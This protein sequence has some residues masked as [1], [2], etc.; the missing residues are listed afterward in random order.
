MAIT[1]VIN[2]C[3]TTKIYCRPDCPAGRRTKPENR[4]TFGSSKEARE[5]GYRA[6]KICKP[7]EP[8]RVRETFFLTRYRGPLGAYVLASSKKGIVCVKTEGQAE[9]YLARW[10]REKIELKEN[11]EHNLS[12]KRQLD[13]YFK[14]K[15]RQFTIPL[16][17][18]GTS[19]QLQV[20]DFL[21]NIPWGE[22]R[23][24]RQIAEA[25]GRPKAS[26]AVGR[27]VGT[28]PA[29]I[30]VPCHRVIGSN[31]TLTGYGGGLDRKAALLKLEGSDVSQQERDISNAAPPK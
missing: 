29:A 1:T 22:T 26:R 2:G 24:Y 16:D 12:L 30:V 17:L 31:G 20:W 8:H 4:V 15:L 10:K 28:N 9:T 14:R 18:R 7:D 6:C 3:R 21:C 11:G 5:K 23:A 27:A 25:L 13:A 19:F